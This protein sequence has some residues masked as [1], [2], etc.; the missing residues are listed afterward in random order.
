MINYE[1]RLYTLFLATHKATRKI[2]IFNLLKSFDL[3]KIFIFRCYN[4][5]PK[6]ETIR[7]TKTFYM[8]IFK[9]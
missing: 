9:L 1:D 4:I 7:I 2:K 6:T 5:V 8:S 3:L